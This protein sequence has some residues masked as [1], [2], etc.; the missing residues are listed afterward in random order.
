MAVLEHDT[1]A[2]AECH[3][4][5]HITNSVI[6]D[7]GKIITANS[8]ISGTS[9][10]RAIVEQDVTSITDIYTVQLDNI[11]TLSS[12]WVVIQNSGTVTMLRSVIDGTI[13]GANANITPRINTVAITNGILVLSFAG[14]LAGDVDI[15]TPTALNSITAGTPIQLE[16]DGASTGTVKAVFT[17]EVTRS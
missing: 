9:E 12:A 5:K 14:S 7:S 13:T 10:F 2:T 17:I 3:E 16:T 15:A 4:P 6:G 8:S 1:I 11:S